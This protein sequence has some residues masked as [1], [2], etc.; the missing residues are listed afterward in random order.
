MET[1]VQRAEIIAQGMVQG[2]GF[3]YFVYRAALKY[4]LKGYTKNLG[5]GDQVLT[6]VEGEKYA[7][8]DLFKIIRTGPAYASVNNCT[9][10]WQPNKN[11]FKTF[12]IR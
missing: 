6:I 3:R 4:N 10:N 12:E 5:S 2:V 9:I 11:E 1:S 7:I 8:E